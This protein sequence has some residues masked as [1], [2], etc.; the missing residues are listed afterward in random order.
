MA[1]IY[2]S[3]SCGDKVI[4]SSQCHIWEGIRISCCSRTVLKY[5]IWDHDLESCDREKPRI[6]CTIMSDTHESRGRY[7]HDLCSYVGSNCGLRSSIRIEL[8]VITSYS[9]FDIYSWTV[10]CSESLSRDL[11]CLIRYS[12]RCSELIFLSTKSSCPESGDI[13]GSRFIS[14]D[15]YPSYSI[16]SCSRSPYSGQS[17]CS[18]SDAIPCFYLDKSSCWH[19]HS[20]CGRERCECSH[21]RDEF[22]TRSSLCDSR[23]KCWHISST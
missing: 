10:E 16:R 8:I 21:D 17:P 13:T 5:D 3:S 7:P 22:P 20:Y 11:K 12:I 1:H 14:D 15:L 19:C 2:Y 23:A 9:F 6:R 4:A 18:K